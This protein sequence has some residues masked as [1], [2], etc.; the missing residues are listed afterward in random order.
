VNL[1]PDAIDEKIFGFGQPKVAAPNPDR[2]IC[3]A[4]FSGSTL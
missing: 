2:G 3:C 1:L 4:L